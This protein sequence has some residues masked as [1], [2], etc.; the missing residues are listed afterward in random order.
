MEK[1]KAIVCTALLV[2]VIVVA[3]TASHFVRGEETGINLYNI[4]MSAMGYCYIGER[5]E[6]FYKWLME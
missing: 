3:L 1:K 6:K 4:I 2:V 5:I